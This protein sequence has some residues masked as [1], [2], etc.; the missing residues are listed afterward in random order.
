MHG[1]CVYL[2]LVCMRLFN[3][4]AISQYQVKQE[5]DDDD[6]LPSDHHIPGEAVINSC[7]ILYNNGFLL[8]V[9]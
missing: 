1:H 8:A 9:A 4:A 5:P 6:V 7:G 3:T 2:L